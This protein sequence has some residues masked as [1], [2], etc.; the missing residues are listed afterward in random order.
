MVYSESGSI[1]IVVERRG[2]EPG[3]GESTRRGYWRCQERVDGV[4]V[5]PQVASHGVKPTPGLLGRVSIESSA[6]HV[7]FMAAWWAANAILVAGS[8]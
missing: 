4:D 8:R 2:S 7:P 1:D 5:V 3:G 6:S